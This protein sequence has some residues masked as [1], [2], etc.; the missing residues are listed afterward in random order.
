MQAARVASGVKLHPSSKSDRGGI[1]NL[2]AD[3]AHLDSKQSQVF[4]LWTFISKCLTKR[5]EQRAH[6]DIKWNALPENALCVCVSRWP[7]EFEA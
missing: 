5:K 6:K 7:N 4:D 1:L 3:Y 2:E